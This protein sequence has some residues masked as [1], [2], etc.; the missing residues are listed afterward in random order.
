MLPQCTS[1]ALSWYPYLVKCIISLISN[2]TIHWDVR[3]LS[4]HPTTGVWRSCRPR[5]S[6]RGQTSSRRPP[7]RPSPAGRSTSECCSR[8]QACK[9]SILEKPNQSFYDFRK[10]QIDQH[11]VVQKRRSR[12]DS[13]ILNCKMLGRNYL[14]NILFCW[15]IT[16][17]SFCM[18]LKK[19]LLGA[20]SSSPLQLARVSSGPPMPL[21]WWGGSYF[22]RRWGLHIT[23][24]AIRSW[25]EMSQ[26]SRV[27]AF[28]W[29][30]RFR[31]WDRPM[32]KLSA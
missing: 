14:Y 19:S 24:G 12:G 11:Y 1:W 23:L 3:Y 2:P 32:P 6:M 9:Y 17:R 31:Y 10:T 18:N 30:K 13:R 22:F 5:G 21:C 29:K 26:E 8:T 28:P 16:N 7:S 27:I 15:L 25:T 4:F 20:T